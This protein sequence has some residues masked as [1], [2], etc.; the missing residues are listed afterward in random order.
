MVQ[1][2]TS[3]IRTLNQGSLNTLVRAIH[4]SGEFSLNIAQCNYHSLQ[5]RLISELRQVSKVD[6][7]HIEL[8]PETTAL[9]STIIQ[10]LGDQRPAALMVS[11][12]D[13]IQDLGSLLQAMNQTREEFRNFEFSLV[14]WVNERVFQTIVRSAHDFFTWGT[15]VRFIPESQ[16]LI[17]FIQQTCCHVYNKVSDRGVGIFLDNQALGLGDCCYQELQAARTELQNRDVSLDRELEARLEFVLGRATDNSTEIAREHYE[18]SLTLWQRASDLTSCALVSSYLGLWW[19]SYGIQ[20]RPTRQVTFARSA[21]YFQQ[22]IQEFEQARQFE[23]AAKFI[24]AWAEVLRRST[25][26]EPENW[27]ALERTTLRAIE[28]HSQNPQREQ[29]C[30][31]FR[32]ARAYGYLA[33]VRLANSKWQEAQHLAEEAL[34]LLTTTLEDEASISEAERDWELSYHQGWYLF[35]LAKAQRGLKHIRQATITLE[36]AQVTTK[37]AYDPELYIQLLQ[38]LR[39]LYYQQKNYLTAFGYKQEQRKI[40]QEFGYRAFVGANRLRVN[41]P[42][43]NPALPYTRHLT[44]TLGVA[45]LGRQQDVEN[46]VQRAKSQEHKLTIIYGQSGVGKS[47]LLQ[48]GLIPALGQETVDTRQVII[49]LQRVYINWSQRLGESLID[50]INARKSVK[51]KLRKLDS[52]EKVL[53]QLQ[54]NADNN[55]LTVLIFDQFEEFFFECQ[56]RQ[57]KQEFYQFLRACFHIPY[58]KVFLS[59]REDY[60]H[61]L[62]EFG[63]SVEPGVLANDI[64]SRKFLYHVG[65]FTQEEV[66]KVIRNLTEKAQISFENTLIERFTQDLTNDLGEIRPIELQIVGLQLE[67]RKRKITTLEQYERLGQDPPKKLIK[68]FLASTV[69]D[70]GRENRDL[71]QLVLY[72]LTNEDNTRP[73][74]PKRELMEELGVDLR[75]LELVLEILYGSGLLLRIPEA[76]GE[77]YQLVHD[78]FVPVMRQ[79]KSAK[80]LAELQEARTAQEKTQTELDNILKRL[81]KT[82]LFLG[83]LTL[84]SL[85]IFGFAWRANFERNRAEIS[86]SDVHRK[87]AKAFLNSNQEL[88]ALKNSLSAAE[89]LQKAGRIKIDD[90]IPVIIMLQEALYKVREFKQLDYHAAEVWD[91]KY[92]Q[93]NQ[94]IASA[95]NDHTV[96]LWQPDGTLITTI[97]GHEAPVYR[98]AFSPDSQVIASVSADQTIKLWQSNGALIRNLEG[99]KDSVYGVAFS[100]TGQT[101]ASASIDNTIKLW[102]LDGTLIRT[103]QGHDDGVENVSFSPYGQTIA[104]ASRDNTIKLWKLDGTLIRTLQEHQDWVYSVEFSPDGQMIASASRDKTIKLWKSNGELIETLKGHKTEAYQATFSP[105][106]STIISVSFD[107]T[108]KLWDI[109]GTFLKTFGKHPQ[110]RGI[111]LSPDQQNM[112]SVGEDK[113]I[114]LWNLTNTSQTKF[115]GHSDAIWSVDVSPDGQRI[116]SASAD[117]TVKLWKADGTLLHTFEGHSDLVGDV[118]FSPDYQTIASASYDGTV[119][120]WS[121]DGRLIRTLSKHKDG[122]LSVKFSPDGQTVV[123]AGFDK[124]IN[125]LNLKN[126]NIKT[127]DAHREPINWIAFKPDGKLFAS[128]SEDGMIKL[129]NLQGQLVQALAGDD[130]IFSIGFHPDEDI[131]VSAGANGVIQIWNIAGQQIG[132]WDAHP[133]GIFSINFSPDGKFI[134]STG[135]NGEIKF[136]SLSGQELGIIQQDNYKAINS[137]KLSQNGDLLVSAGDDGIIALWSFSLDQ[138]ISEGCSWLENYRSE[139]AVA[140]VSQPQQIRQSS[141]VTKLPCSIN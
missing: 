88:E 138:L 30:G 133:R 15:T 4:F 110:A 127:L 23:L 13:C 1:P 105:D 139:L 94:M 120:L 9:C 12:F 117:N 20:H 7:A 8:E 48:A 11:G 84:L 99:H 114:R 76:L 101:I 130:R 108:I 38:V 50:Q 129:W 27:K 17:Q 140:S 86:Q 136:W 73:L 87:A 100:P 45:A 77:R 63:R 67:T 93:D 46:L 125:I 36:E 18:R 123:S 134:I 62:L 19:L 10:Y 28:L 97:R 2:H 42:I 102:R 96:K 58:V 44:N 141:F 6:L 60:L 56:F 98:V 119:K 34:N 112:A 59:L 128:A 75:K 91:V 113:T 95:S 116:V 40:E 89:K 47:S 107:N 57:Q 14:L 21:Q 39:E 104:S 137:A 132:E 53:T 83:I 106:G 24:N 71:A 115:Q 41:Q 68:Q 33:E 31:K 3:D 43:N 49:T 78:Y 64:L 131:I 85:I 52:I 69:D 66:R 109:D 118:S 16:E 29:P 26:W 22:S 55:L 135:T 80:L 51:E 111:A 121:I 90:K 5:Q 82:R 92:S 126:Q 79:R 37:P 65:N 124:K 25:Q 72:L 70:C 74:K 32:L 54:E 61:Y 103:F 81:G 122:A 35:S